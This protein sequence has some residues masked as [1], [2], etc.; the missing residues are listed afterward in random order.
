MIGVPNCAAYCT[1]AQALA[2]YATL[3]TSLKKEMNAEESAV[4]AFGGSY[5]GML[6]AWVRIKVYDF[7]LCLKLLRLF[8]SF[9]LYSPF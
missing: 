5:G 6:A 3:A 9:R 4:V 1:S 8:F 2:D 7:R